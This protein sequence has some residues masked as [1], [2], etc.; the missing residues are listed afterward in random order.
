MT[1]TW[2]WILIYSLLFLL[3]G[4]LVGL[5]NKTGQHR[6]DRAHRRH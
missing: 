1:G 3:G 2:D 5:E 6:R 4:M